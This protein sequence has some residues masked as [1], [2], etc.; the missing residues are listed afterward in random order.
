MR[1]EGREEKER[2]VA[3]ISPFT[4]MAAVMDSSIMRLSEE[5]REEDLRLV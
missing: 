5:I 3:A 2:E 1:M 4:R